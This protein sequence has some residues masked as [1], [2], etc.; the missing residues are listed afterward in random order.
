MGARGF[1][2]ATATSTSVV[3]SVGCSTTTTS[4]GFPTTSTGVGCSTTTTTGVGCSTSTIGV[5][6]STSTTGDTGVCPVSC[7]LVAE[8]TRV[9]RDRQRRVGADV[10]FY[11]FIFLSLLGKLCFHV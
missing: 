5:G 9:R 2:P 1:G 3:Q 11:I 7:Q 6:Y 10:S 8:G 4:V